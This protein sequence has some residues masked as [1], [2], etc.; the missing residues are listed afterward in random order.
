[1][2]HTLLRRVSLHYSYCLFQYHFPHES[3]MVSFFAAEANQEKLS[4]AEHAAARTIYDASTWTHTSNKPMA[5]PSHKEVEQAYMAAYDAYADGLFRFLVSKV[6]DREVARDLVQETFT[7]AWDYCLKG[8][9]VEQW[10]PFLFRTAYNLVVDTYRKRRTISLDALIEDS[11]FAIPDRDDVRSVNRAEA[12]RIRGAMDLLDG[13]YRDVLLLRYSEDLPPREI[14][15]I[16]GLTENVVSVRIHRG[17]KILR[18]H[19]QFNKHI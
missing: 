9:A 19:M 2:S 6:S 7:R 13:P 3:G 14:A 1:M 11:G 18:E 10:K 15:R 8:G 17:I 5:E 16:M 4:G 12:A